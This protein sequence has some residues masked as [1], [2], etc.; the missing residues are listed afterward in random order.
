MKKIKLN[1][2]Y[3]CKYSEECKWNRKCNECPY[4]EV[5]QVKEKLKPKNRKLKINM[6]K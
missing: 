2:T 3:L 4:S 5:L 1:I 6:F